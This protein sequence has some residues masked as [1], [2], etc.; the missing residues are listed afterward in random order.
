MFIAMSRFTVA[1]GHA[2]EVEEAF[3]NRP[4]QVDQAP[5]FRAMRVL[6]PS[7]GPH[8]FALITE[9]DDAESYR[10]RHRG[11][12]YKHAHQGIPAGLKLVPGK[13]CIE[14]FSVLCD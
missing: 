6:R 9:W 14:T 5:G 13:T 10:R 1:S 2:A 11:H 12:G 7:E 3:R 8:E 4:H